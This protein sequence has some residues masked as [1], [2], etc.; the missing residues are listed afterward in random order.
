MLSILPVISAVLLLFNKLGKAQVAKTL[1]ILCLLL[2]CFAPQPVFANA[3]PTFWQGYPSSE[4]LVIDENCPVEVAAETLLFRL[5]ADSSRS[6]T[7]EG[8]VTASYDMVN[9]SDKDLSVQMAF[10]F[11]CSLADFFAGDIDISVDGTTL[12]CNLYIGDAINSHTHG[13]PGQQETKASLIFADILDTVTDQPYRAQNFSEHEQGKLYTLKVRPTTEQRINLA[14]EFKLEDENTKVLVDGFNRYEGDHQKVRIASWCYEPTVLELLVLGDDIDLNITAYTDGE[15][16]QKTDLYDCPV[17]AEETDLKSYIIR[18]VRGYEK[19]SPGQAE[20]E[21]METS[22]GFPDQQLYNMYAAALDRV[23]TA[24]R[25][26]CSSD[27][28]IAQNHSKRV[29]TLVYTVDFPHHSRRNMSVSYKTTGTM[30]KRKTAKPVYT[31]NYILNPAQNWNSF[32]N[33]TMEILTPEEAPYIVHS[34][35]ELSKD[36]ERHYRTSLAAL[37]ED[38]FVFSIYAREKITAWDKIYGAWQNT[39]GYFTPFVL[40]GSV[41]IALAVISTVLL[42][43]RRRKLR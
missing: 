36:K 4:V 16:K 1:V 11:V 43:T 17:S 26:F 23:L 5:G 8:Q 12:P 40:G 6:Y 18:Y 7:M 25:G 20:I 19:T 33:L 27:D 10:P 28:L 21:D 29:M 37:P 41:I 22:F 15:L 38:D 9:P 31:F 34:N 39:F 42:I 14:V 32:K 3:G 2:S 35:I 13:H 24:N 30:D